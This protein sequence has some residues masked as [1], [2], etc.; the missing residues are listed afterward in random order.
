MSA[1]VLAHP[2]WHALTRLRLRWDAYVKPLPWTSKQFLSMPPLSTETPAMRDIKAY[3]YPSAPPDPSMFEEATNEYREAATDTEAVAALYPAVVDVDHPST[4]LKNL[5][6]EGRLQDASRVHAE[7][8]DMGFEIPHHPVYHF[9]ARQALRDPE[10]SQKERVDALIKWWSLVPP[11]TEADSYRSVKSILA[12]TL[13]NDI[14]PDIPVLIQFAILAASKGYALEVS[15]DIIRA[16]ARYAPS[17]VVLP[18]L[19]QFCAAAWKVKLPEDSAD[20]L[21]NRLFI[22]DWPLWHCFAIEELAYYG[23]TRL[24]LD[25]LRVARARDFPLSQSAYRALLRALQRESDDDAIAMVQTVR[26]S[27]RRAQGVPV[28]RPAIE[29]SLQSHGAPQLRLSSQDLDRVL[30]ADSVLDG[31]LVSVARALKRAMKTGYLPVSGERLSKLIRIFLALGRTTLVRRLR[32]LAY[33]HDHLVSLWT[34][35]DLMRHKSRRSSI[36]TVLKDF[37]SHFHLVGVPSRLFDELWRERRA[38]RPADVAK[39]RPPLRRKLTPTPHHMYILWSLLVSRARTHSE[40]Q[41]LYSSFLEEVAA[42]RDVPVSSV[43]FLASRRP[44]SPSNDAED[45]VRPVPPPILFNARHFTLF[46]RLFAQESPVIALRVIVD[47]YALGIEPDDELFHKFVLVLK[48]VPPAYPLSRVVASLERLI[49]KHKSPVERS[50]LPADSFPQPVDQQLGALSRAQ[51]FKEDVLVFVYTA[52]LRRLL[53]DG[54]GADPDA[55]KIAGRFIA[56]VPY[57]IG[58]NAMTDQ[59]LHPPVQRA[60]NVGIGV[61]ENGDEESPYTGLAQSEALIGVSQQLSGVIPASGS[62]DED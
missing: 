21:R 41:R 5:V 30:N 46:I 53:L 61:S 56:R 18:F 17:R 31:G 37:E 45:D 3:P 59:V 34:L 15:H 33:R 24:A 7:L 2:P 28:F 1:W 12:E 25:V 19:K 55:T 50:Y 10:L 40:R 6:L 39:W 47:M 14:A 44:P 36:Y 35:V 43:P 8:L 42:S 4:L 48:R 57:R 60:R 52:A 32:S 58:T 23:R 11:K 38:M 62:R 27:Q 54:R 22:H 51:A 26:N 13:R 16:V 20:R 9:A 49:N 29:K